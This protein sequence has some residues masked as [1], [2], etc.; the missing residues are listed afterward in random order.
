[1][2]IKVLSAKQGAIKYHFLSIWYDLTWDQTLVSQ[3]IGKHS[4]H[5]A[6]ESMIMDTVC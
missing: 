1:M 5:K 4:T 2:Y 3:A 6:K